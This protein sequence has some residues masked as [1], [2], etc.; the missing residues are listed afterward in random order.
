MPSRENL[1]GY[2]A[3]FPPLDLSK[4]P[5]PNGTPSAD[6]ASDAVD[7]SHACSV[8]KQLRAMYEEAQLTDIVV[9]VDHGKTFSCHRNVLAAISPYFR[10]EGAGLL[11]VSAPTPL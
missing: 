5:T 2:T 9:E 10:Y 6:A 1:R 7:P 4:S 8:L 3:S 11:L